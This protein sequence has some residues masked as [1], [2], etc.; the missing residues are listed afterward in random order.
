M[1]KRVNVIVLYVQEI[2]CD[3]IDS[4][5]YK[6]KF[7]FKKYRFN[8]LKSVKLIS[9][10]YRWKQKSKGINSDITDYC[11]ISYLFYRKEITSDSR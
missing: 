7:P 6:T 10:K 1:Y 5:T 3:I 11:H 4:L 2:T 8:M 9:S